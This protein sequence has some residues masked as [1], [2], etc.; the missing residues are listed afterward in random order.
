MQGE[1]KMSNSYDYKVE[2]DSEKTSALALDFFRKNKKLREV[3]SIYCDYGEDE[4][5]A[6]LIETDGNVW[7]FG[8]AGCCSDDI[9]VGIYDY[10]KSKCDKFSFKII[11][12]GGDDFF[13]EEG[14]FA[15]VNICEFDS[16]RHRILSAID[17]N[18]KYK[19][20]FEQ[21]LERYF[22]ENWDSDCEEEVSMLL[23]RYGFGTDGEFDVDGAKL[24]KFTEDLKEI[25]DSLLG[26]LTLKEV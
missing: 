12:V 25:D 9:G 21:S 24:G 23:E 14:E 19:L 8:S 5:P 26:Y 13:D 18:G 16:E 4:M 20:G 6:D 10:L 7:K 17:E 3:A 1:T 15:E 2:F 22:Q 11:L